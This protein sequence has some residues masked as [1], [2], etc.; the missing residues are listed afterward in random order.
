[1]ASDDASGTLTRNPRRTK[2][3][4][5]TMDSKRK[6]A[7]APKVPDHA[8]RKIGNVI[9]AG[10]LEFNSRLATHGVKANE[11]ALDEIT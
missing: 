9:D 10:L 8:E 3:A 4:S 1:M 7:G 6:E 2:E 11:I 5:R